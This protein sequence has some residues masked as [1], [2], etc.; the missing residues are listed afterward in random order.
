M[1]GASW[2]KEKLVVNVSRKQLHFFSTGGVEVQEFV[3]A[4]GRV[5]G[6]PQQYSV[7][8]GRPVRARY[9]DMP[10]YG[11]KFSSEKSALFL[12]KYEAYI[13]EV[14]AMN[15]RQA[16]WHVLEE[17]AVSDLPRRRI[18]HCLCDTFLSY[19]LDVGHQEVLFSL[20][21]HASYASSSVT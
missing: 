8:D 13:R 14:R 15:A 17:P 1:V 3:A 5:V 10:Y 11:C 12:R 19:A 21:K 9:L 6:A 4:N 7:I 2:C 20:R 16:H 18:E